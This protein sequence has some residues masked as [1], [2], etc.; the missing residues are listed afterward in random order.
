M[1]DLIAIVRQAEC[2][3]GAIELKSWHAAA[4]ASQFCICLFPSPAWLEREPGLAVYG[5]GE[6]ELNAALNTLRYSVLTWA[7]AFVH[8][9][10]SWEPSDNW[11]EPTALREAIEGLKAFLPVE[12]KCVPA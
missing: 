4:N 11:P 6:K 1:I 10:A 9:A 2:L 12:S 7:R 5:P 3:L 8:P